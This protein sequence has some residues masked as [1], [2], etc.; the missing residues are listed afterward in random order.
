MHISKTA[1][2]TFTTFS[3]RITRGRDSALFLRRRDTL[4]TS[5]F[6]DGVVFL[7]TGP[8]A[9]RDVIA[10]VSMQCFERDNASAVLCDIGYVLS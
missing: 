4:C 8:M 1:R 7:V 6:A 2:R 9:R 10:I 3:V 5:G